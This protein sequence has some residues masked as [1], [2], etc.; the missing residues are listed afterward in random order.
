MKATDFLEQQH[1]EVEDL[2]EQFENTDEAKKKKAIFQQIA[3]KLTIHAKLEEKFLYPVGRAVDE[4]VTLESY[5]E[6]DL[7]KALIRKIQKTRVNDEFYDAR[8]TVLKEIVEHHV[9][10][11]EEE[12]FPK[13]EKELSEEQLEELG[14]KLEAGFE[15]LMGGTKRGGKSSYAMAA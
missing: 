10:E 2:F 11:E 3:E 5:E 12:Y 9:E 14:E 7:V 6:H 1:R 4:D 15:R 8:V 13:L